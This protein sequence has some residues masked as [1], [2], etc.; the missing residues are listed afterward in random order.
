MSLAKRSEAVETLRQGQAAVDALLT[1]LSP[2]EMERSATIGDGDWSAKD[3]IG[4]LASWEGL[5]LLSLKEWRRGEIPWVER[6]EGPFSAPATGKVDAFNARAVAEQA[7]LTL[8]EVRTRARATHREL[9]GAIEAMTDQ[10]W[11]A[12]ASY[13]TPNNRRRRLGTLLGSITAAPQRPFGH[14]F[15]H[16]PDLEAFVRS[17]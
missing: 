11:T 1:A 15:A 6:P 13:P 17:R 16:V 7:A 2:A 8:D 12:T 4:H 5:A 14:A 10:E 3:L 9:I